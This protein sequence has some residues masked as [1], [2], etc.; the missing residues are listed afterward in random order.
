M[1]EH[2]VLNKTYPQGKLASYFMD[3]NKLTLKVIW[4]PQIVNTILKKNHVGGLMVSNLKTY[5]NT[6]EIKTEWYW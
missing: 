6:T 1:L 5:Y 2:S 4:R 3:I